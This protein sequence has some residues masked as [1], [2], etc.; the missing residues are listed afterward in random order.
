MS[1]IA[2]PSIH[3]GDRWISRSTFGERVDRALGGLV[4][5]GAR[6]GTRVGLLGANGPDWLAIATAAWRLGAPLVPL[7]PRLSAAELGW[8]ARRAKVQVLLADPEF[9]DAAPGA[10]CPMDGLFDN[11]GTVQ[12]PPFDL[13]R[14][15][16]RR[17][18]TIV[19]TSGSTGRPK[20]AILTGR[21]HT[22]HARASVQAIS[23]TSA[24][25]WLLC[26]PLYHVGGLNILHRCLRAG[27][28]IVLH[29]E[30][31]PQEVNHAIDAQG[32]TIVSLVETMLRR[33]VASRGGRPFPP[34]LRAIIA[35]GGPIGTDLV[36][37]FPAVL[38]SYGLTE[39]CSMVT[40]VRPD[41]ARADRPTAGRPLPGIE[42]RIVDPEGHAVPTGTD[43][44]IEI[45]GPVVMKGYLDDRGATRDAF[46][47]GWLRTGDIGL[48]DPAGNLCVAARREDLILSGGE[49]IYPAEIEAALRA[50]PAVVDVAV[51]G[52][53]DPEWGQ[54][55]LAV[56]V[57][58]SAEA[59]AAAQDARDNP[60]GPG[61]PTAEDLERHL[62]GLIARFKLPRIVFAM[63][64]PRLPGGKPDRAALRARYA[65][66]A[67]GR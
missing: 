52:V 55:P 4:T 22:S 5:I 18:R 11:R 2:A 3:W 31:D 56:V 32:V 17:P 40:L 13:P 38:P 65:A 16:P 48:I 7:S 59:A 37:A 29:R 67:G 25:R 12:R 61:T 63:E 26:M 58:A 34:S 46:R 10:A 64:L 1:P 39:S 62:G 53:D 50:H 66:G 19:F 15:D 8:Q 44:S 49:N 28:A 30:F 6:P 51:I 27:A 41:A 54:R 9:V 43:G 20:G 21:N 35:G 23:L 57:V 47:D 36:E 14:V 45:R 33:V 42:I 24:D 60:A